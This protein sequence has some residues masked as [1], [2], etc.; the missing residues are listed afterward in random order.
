MLAKFE[1]F[2]VKMEL[3]YKIIK[4]YGAKR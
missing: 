3:I 2:R 4:I 1:K